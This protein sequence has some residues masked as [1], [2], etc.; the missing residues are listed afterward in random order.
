ME[1]GHLGSDKD[2]FI[3]GLT[4]CMW[5]LKCILFIFVVFSPSIGATSQ[6]HFESVSTT[7]RIMM[8]NATDTLIAAMFELDQLF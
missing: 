7:N 8:S 5:T 2:G 4:F 1:Q 3:P 6:N